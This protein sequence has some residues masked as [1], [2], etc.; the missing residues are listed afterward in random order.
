[1]SQDL[2]YS[3]SSNRI[4]IWKGYE[5]FSLVNEIETQYGALYSIATSKRFILTGEEI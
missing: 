2:L 1:M 4:H 5:D 3:C